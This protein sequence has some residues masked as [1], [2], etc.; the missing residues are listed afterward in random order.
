MAA[1]SAAPAKSQ[2]DPGG[3]PAYASR[4]LPTLTVGIGGLG[5]PENATG[6]SSGDSVDS[7]A[8]AISGSELNIA[9]QFI[10]LAGIESPEILSGIRIY[11]SGGVLPTLGFDIDVAKQGDPRGFVYPKQAE[12]NA[13]Y[14]G[15]AIDGT[16][17]RSSAQIGR[18]AW[19]ANL[20]VSL[21]VDVGEHRLDVR[22]SVGYFRY[23]VNAQGVRLAAIK[24]DLVDPFVR[25]ISL[26]N[27][28]TEAFSSI[29][30][31]LELGF[32]LGPK[33]RFK[34]TLF[35]DASFYHVLGDRVI[36]MS[37]SGS[38]LYG[39]EEA[40]WTVMVNPWIYRLGA[41]LR[42]AWTGD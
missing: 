15:S 37:D 38:D 27:S 18:I 24:P 39:T 19:A 34:P 22:P 14:P 40:Y 8:V 7:Q 42:V 31:C 16:G 26:E 3:R 23:S 17:I 33:G 41:G 4:W 20:G 13:P 30:P 36:E 9:P 28:R 11:T 35:L 21:G 6:S 12:D 1:A 32:D 29:G 25:Q 2:S 5:D 10:V